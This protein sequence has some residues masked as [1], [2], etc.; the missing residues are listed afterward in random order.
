MLFES[1]EYAP[2]RGAGG[3]EWYVVKDGVDAVKLIVKKAV[4]IVNE[5][6]EAGK[7]LD[8]NRTPN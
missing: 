7:Y 5:L 8:S 6:A 3:T 4:D 2:K 1:A